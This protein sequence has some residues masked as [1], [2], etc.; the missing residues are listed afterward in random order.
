MG[1]QS[2]G[3]KCFSSKRSRRVQ[4]RVEEADAG[5]LG[6]GGEGIDHGWPKCSSIP[7]GSGNVSLKT[8][9]GP[10]LA[11]STLDA[12]VLWLEGG[13]GGLP[14]KIMRLTG[15]GDAQPPP[16]RG[17]AIN[18]GDQQRGSRGTTPQSPNHCENLE[19][20]LH[21]TQG[22]IP[23][24]NAL[25]DSSIAMAGEIDEIPATSTVRPAPSPC[26]GLDPVGEGTSV[27][28]IST[29]QSNSWAWSPCREP[30][31]SA[32]GVGRGKGRWRWRAV[33]V[34]VVGDEA[35]KTHFLLMI[36]SYHYH[37]SPH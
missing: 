30:I 36:A 4:Q 19:L 27:S 14:F 16:G 5:T 24:T 3:K 1:K 13:V 6:W 23:G 12:I 2:L 35:G 32:W 15:R 18:P 29:S 26:D 34:A 11:V 28:E 21:G 25:A 20:C 31:P 17:E 9:N 22:R 37:L 33:G 8:A 7:S 10:V